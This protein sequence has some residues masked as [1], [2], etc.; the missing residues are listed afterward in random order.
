MPLKVDYTNLNEILKGGVKYVEIGKR[1]VRTHHEWDCD[2][3]HVIRQLNSIEPK[4]NGKVIAKRKKITFD[5]EFL[6]KE[7][8]QK[9]IMKRWKRVKATDDD[10]PEGSLLEKM[11]AAESRRVFKR[12][13]RVIRDYGYT[14]F[15]QTGGRYNDHLCLVAIG[16]SYDILICLVKIDPRMYLKLPILGPWTTRFRPKRVTLEQYDDRHTRKVHGAVR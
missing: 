6:G 13:I 8:V 15:K 10:M 5:V 12:E 14:G 2:P 3:H 16:V 11:V 4:I 1:R 9:A 7:R